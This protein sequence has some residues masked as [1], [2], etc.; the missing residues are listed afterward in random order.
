MRN[1]LESNLYA[2]FKK[3]SFGKTSFCC[4][5]YLLTACQQ[6][7]KLSIIFERICFLRRQWNIRNEGETLGTSFK[8]II[9]Y[10]DI[11]IVFINS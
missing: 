4:F 7:N 11:L 10:F 2:E 8:K 5:Y 3:I 1:A 9:L 6:D